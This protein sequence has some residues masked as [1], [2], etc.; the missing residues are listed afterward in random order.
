MVN[1]CAAYMEQFVVTSY[2]FMLG[3]VLKKT[4]RAGN[5]MTSSHIN[6]PGKLIKRPCK[7]KYSLFE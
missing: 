6:M 7:I 4:G 3:L 2:P 5:L 1:E